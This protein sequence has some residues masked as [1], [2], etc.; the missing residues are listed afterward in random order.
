MIYQGKLKISDKLA[1]YLPEFRNSDRDNIIIKHLLIY[2]VDG[3]SLSSFKRKAVTEILDILF[4][5]DFKKRPG[6]VFKYTNLTATLLGMVAERIFGET[7]DVL[8]DKTKSCGRRP[9][10][11]CFALR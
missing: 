2:T 8:A 9:A 1:D 5:R 7:L 10:A 4:T 6:T 3:Y 11:L